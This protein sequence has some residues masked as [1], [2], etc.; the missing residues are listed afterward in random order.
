M[1]KDHVSEAKL[2]EKALDVLSKRYKL[3]AAFLPNR[4]SAV[5]V[6]TR[7]RLFRFTAAA[8]ADANGKR[9]DIILDASGEE[10][11]S[12]DARALFAPPATLPTVPRVAP[13]ASVTVTPATNVLTLNPGDCFD[14]TVTVKIPKDVAPPRVDVYFLADTTGSMGPFLNAVQNGANAIFTALNGLGVDMSFGVGNYRDFPSDAYAFQHQLAPTTNAAQI[15]AAIGAW[16]AAGGADYP[17]GQ[18]YALD[19]LAK[20][21]GGTIGW[22]AGSKR[23]IVWFGDAPGHD[24]VCAAISG[25]PNTIT[26]ASA[27]A[28]LVAE[29]IAVLAISTATPGLDD[30]PAAS[31]FDYTTTCGAPGGAA[32]QASRISNATGGSFATGVQPSDIVTTITTLVTS[33]VNTINNVKLV[34]SGAIAPFV[35]SIDPAAGFGPLTTDTEHV[36]PFEVKFCGNVP[37]KNEDQVFDGRLGVVADG[38]LIG[39]KRVRVTVP[40]CEDEFVYS[41]KFVCGTRDA[42][43]CDPCAPV[44]VGRYASKI[45]IHNFSAREVRIRKRV[46]PVVFAGV[47]SGREPGIA[48]SRAADAIVLPPHSATMDD[49]CR[50]TELLF[51][52]TQTSTLNIGFLEITAN[53]E[54]AV[55]AVYT[56]SG[57][58]GNVAVDVEQIHPRR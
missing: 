9:F 15:T 57:S 2:G 27:T 5:H 12:D 20:P 24:P 34:P 25:E 32:G 4:E 58:A 56:V 45:N 48:E 10:R 23:I 49:C 40:A 21:P 7:E 16:N 31:A 33:A 29:S 44:A 13:L 17:E 26:E 8:D 3:K 30:D 19:Q 11:D 47:G 14:E 54:L 43:G 51:G 22:R 42:D 55:T 18:L 38:S 46:L 50:L 41:V 35:T 52:G 1:V 53:A 37:C 36:L 28:K 39:H 6:E